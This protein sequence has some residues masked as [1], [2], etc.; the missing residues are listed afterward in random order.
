MNVF[1]KAQL[2][3]ASYVLFDYL[4]NDYSDGGVVDIL[5][6]AEQGGVFTPTQAE[7]FVN[8]WRV[9]SHTKNTSNGY[10]ATLFQSKATGEYVYAIRGTEPSDPINDISETD[11]GDIVIDGLALDQIVDMYNDWQRLITPEG[12]TFQAA[13]LTDLEAE[14]YALRLTP[15]GPARILHEQML[16][17]QGDIVIDG[18]GV[19]ATVRR[20][21]FDGSME[22]MPGSQAYG[23]GKLP[24]DQTVTAVG[25]SLG[26]HLAAGFTRL[27][28]DSNAAEA[29]TLNGAG[30]ATFG[31]GL[32][33][34]SN[35]TNLFGMLGGAS[36]FEASRIQNLYGS[37]GPEI[38]TM[39]FYLGLKQQGGHTGIFI[40]SWDDDTTW[41]HGKE[42]MTDALAIMDLFVRLDASLSTGDFALVSAR[43]NPIFEAA[44]NNNLA[45]FEAVLDAW[46]ALVLTG[47]SPLN[48][49]A[50]NRESLYSRIYAIRDALDGQQASVVSLVGLGAQTITDLA[51]APGGEA[52]RAALLA[53]SPFA[54]SGLDYTTRDGVSLYDPATGQ[55]ELTT[56]WLRDRAELLYWKLELALID[57]VT[58]AQIPL[59]DGDRGLLL[60]DRASGLLMHIHEVGDVPRI[61][62]GGADADLI[63]VPQTSLVGHRFYGGA[64]ADSLNGG[65]NSDYFEGGSGNDHLNGGKGNDTLIGGGDNDRYEF[66]TGDGSD[67]LIDSD[68]L[69][70]LWIDETHYRK[71]KKIAQGADTWVS[72]DNN[73]RFLRSGSDLLV[74]YG[75]GDSILIRNYVEGALGLTLEGYAPPEPVSATSVITGTADPDSLDGTTGD[76]RILGLDGND[77]IHYYVGDVAEGHD[78]LIGGAGSDV[79]FGGPGND[80]IYA[81]TEI[82]Q[83]PANPLPERGGITGDWLDGGSGADLIVGSGGMDGIFGGPGADTI[84]AGDGDDFIYSDDVSYA[85]DPYM[86]VAFGAGAVG[87][88][89]HRYVVTRSGTSTPLTDENADDVIMAGEGNDL[90]YSNR[91]NDY[92]EGNAGDDYLMG[93]TGNDSLIGGEDNDTL[94]GDGYDI[95]GEIYELKKAPGAEHGNDLLIGGQGN[96]LLYGNGGHDRLLGGEGQD[97]LF[98]DD[99]STPR[100]YHG[101][102]DLDGGAQD[103]LLYGLGGSDTL[104]GGGGNDKL[105]GDSDGSAAVPTTHGA[106]YLD[107]GEGDDSLQGDGGDDVLLGGDG[108]DRLDGDDNVGSDGISQVTGNDTLLGGAG[109]DQLLGGNGNDYL[110]GGAGADSLWGGLDND[111]LLGGDGDDHLEGRE[112]DDFL[113]GGLGDDVLLGGAGADTLQGGGGRDVLLGGAGD[114]LYLLKLSDMEVSEGLMGRIDDSDGHSRVHLLDISRANLSLRD[115]G[116][117]H[118]VLQVD[119]EHQMQVDRGLSGASLE[120]QFSDGRVSL[121]RLLGEAL[122]S[123]VARTDTT[124]TGAVYGG[125]ADDALTVTGAGGGATISGGRGND[126][127]TLLAVGGGTLLFS[128]GD[129]RDTLIGESAT[130]P[131][132]TGEN[133]LRLG[134]GIAFDDLRLTKTGTVSYVLSIGSEG[135]AILFNALGASKLP[136][137]FD[138][139]VFND[140]TEVSWQQVL[141]SGIHFDVNT[142]HITG[143]ETHDLITGSEV[144]R[145][146]EALEGND[147]IE[148]GVGSE[149]LLGGRGNDTYILNAGFGHDEISNKGALADEADRIIFG[150]GLSHADARFIR[151]GNDLLVWFGEIDRLRI[152]G[153]FSNEGIETLEFA[154]GQVFDRLHLPPYE[155]VQALATEETDTFGLGPGDDYF[156]ALGGDDFIAGEDGNDRLI[157][158]AGNDYLEG[159]AGDDWL[160]GGHGQDHLN[161]GAGVDTYE[162]SLTGLGY[163]R[164][165]IV[166]LDSGN[167]L[168][169][170]GGLRAQDVRVIR[171]Q[172]TST[173]QLWFLHGVNGEYSVVR[174][175][176]QLRGQGV[177]GPIAQVRFEAEPDVIWSAADLL[178][179]ALTGGPDDE[180]IFGLVDV[181][182]TLLGGGGNDRLVGGALDDHLDGEAGNDWL[183]GGAGNDRYTYGLGA[184]NDR[185]TDLEGL[186]RVELAQGLTPDDIELVRTAA[187]LNGVTLEHDS[188]VLVLR[189]SGESLVLEHFFKPGDA[190]TAVHFYDGT[191]WS[192]AELGLR[193]GNSVTGP[194]DTQTGGAG[195]DEFQ[196]DNPLDQVVELENGG[197]DNIISSVSYQLPANVENLQLTG[198]LSIDATGNNANNVLRGNAGDN[199]LDGRQGSDTYI[200]GAGNDTYIIR[201]NN[202]YPI[203][204]IFNLMAGLSFSLEERPGEGIDSI[205]TNAFVMHMPEEVEHLRVTSLID[206]RRIEFRGSGD[207]VCFRYTGNALNNRID[208]S[209]ADFGSF[210]SFLNTVRI[211]GGAGADTMLGSNIADTYVVD[212]AGD[213]IIEQGNSIDTVESRVSWQLGEKLENLLLT[214]DSATEGLGNELDNVLNGAENGAANR[215]SGFTGDDTYLIGLND[216]VIEAA[217]EGRDT[218]HLNERAGNTS[219][220]FHAQQWANIEV[221]KVGDKLGSVDLIGDDR[222][223]SLYGNYLSNLLE[224]GAGNDILYGASL[225]YNSLYKQFDYPTTALDRFSGGDG[226]DRI[227]AFGGHAEIEGGAGADLIELDGVISAEVEGGT[228]NDLIRLTGR[229]SSVAL[230]FGIGSGQDTVVSDH[231]RTAAA[232]EQDKNILSSVVVAADTQASRLRFTRE[233]ADM[234]VSLQ[235]STDSLRI[236]AFY[237]SRSSALIQSPIDSIRLA[238]GTLLNR[239]AIA[240]GLGRVEFSDATTAD[241]LLIADEASAVLSAGD[242]NDYLFGQAGEDHL[243]GEAGNDQLSGGGGADLLSGGAGDDLLMGGT[244][245]DLYTLSAGWGQDV[246]DDSQFRAGPT[247]FND[248]GAVDRILFDASVTADALQLE[249]DGDDLVLRH[250]SDSLRVVNY[251]SAGEHNGQVEEICFADGTLW[252]REQVVRM[253]NSIMGTAGNDVLTGL[254]SESLVFGLGGDDTL[255]GFGTLDGGEGNDRIDG[256]GVLHGGDGQDHLTGQGA[257]RLEGGAGDDLLI[258]YDHVWEPRSSTLEGGQGNDTLYGSFGEDSYLF[259][260]GDGRDLLIERR[261]DQA[262]SNV[263]ASIDYLHFGDGIVA[264]DLVFSRQGQDLLIEHANG[265]DAIT[266]QNWFRG[267]TAHFKLDVFSFAD[268]SELSQAEIEARV[269]YKGTSAADNLVGTDENDTFLG[270]AGNDQIWGRAGDDLIHGEAGNDYLEGELG[271]DE[272]YGGLGNDQLRGGAG[273]DL[274]AGGAGDDTY[275]Y[276]LGDGA[277]E[278]QVGG[279]QDGLFFNGGITVE[280]LSFSREQDDLLIRVDQDDAQS[281]R[282]VG[283][284]LGGHNALSFVQPEGGSMLTA[285]RIAQIISGEVPPG[286]GGNTV[287]GTA[288]NDQLS[289][290]AGTDVLRGLAGNDTLFGMGGD[291]QIEGGDGDDYLS[292]GN[293]QLG[294]SGNDLLNGGAGND[295]LAGEDGNDT[296]IGGAGDDDYYYRVNGGVDVIDNSGGGFDG[297]FFLDVPRSRLSF[298]RDGDDLVV[299]VDGDL[300]QQVRVTNHF[301]GGDHSIDYVQPDG[302]NYLTT[303]QIAAQLTAVPGGGEEPGEPEEPGNPGGP[304]EPPVAGVGGDDLLV[305]TAGNDIL[306]GGAGNDTLSGA[307]GND[308]LLGGVGEDTYTYTAGQ[309]VIEEVGGADTLVFAG[310]ITFNQVASGL[311]KSGNDLV[312]RVNGST[313]N[314]V[315]LKNFFLGGDNLVETIAFETGGQLTAAQIFGAFGLPV[316]TPAAAFDDIIQGSIGDDALDGTAGNDLLQGGNGDD[317][318]FGDAGADRLEGGNGNDVLAG[319]AGNDTLV[320]G[321]S[322]DTYVF[323]VGGGQDVID[324]SGGGADTLRFEGISFNQVASGLMKSGN[325][326]VLNV[327]GGSDKV[328]IR[329]W[330]LGGDYVVDTIAFASGGQVTA[331]QLFGAFGLSNP[332]PLGSLIYRHLPDER[333]FGTV[334][335]GQAG[336]QIIRGSSDDDLIDGGAGND[337][338]CGNTGHDYL[339]GGAGNDT[340]V[341]AA[342]DG[343]DVI[344]NLSNTPDADSDVLS[345][346]DIGRENL[347]LSRQGDDLVIDVTGTEDSITI[348]DWYADPAQQLDVIQ[349]GSSSLSANQVDN[350][351]NAMAAFGAP[352][353]GEI[354]LTSVQRDQLNT[355]I[356]ANWQ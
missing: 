338:L 220:V 324:N 237:E 263:E 257:D 163:S 16:L 227:Y 249:I 207:D 313:A 116:G 293:G 105:Y 328:T 177:F 113:N 322:D 46:G 344:N 121:D 169:M 228:G 112:G 96:D 111:T 167:Q 130:G 182:N 250:Q 321:R 73:V 297:V 317:E 66:A 302:G 162:I 83:G 3:E 341:F 231:I 150:E 108:N 24:F 155:G 41:G 11:I 223:N 53:L 334:L 356:A 217:G 239:D 15:P 95:A 275:V 310:G 128:A 235:G 52:Y 306:L 118:L 209:S 86:Q 256:T 28:G 64:G 57:G 18:T 241:D 309:D 61:I 187:P 142:G 289:G 114:D 262:Y 180:G 135:D 255:E 109:D 229:P 265:E 183:L 168:I 91:G 206:V 71:G 17:A 47:Y 50:E 286:G 45:S 154:D 122:L 193:A 92:V 27:F 65:G 337:T 312:L 78:T 144:A 278:I 152:T 339:I 90:V 251:F 232:W 179:M 159:N 134:E 277:D 140:G 12:Q 161:G 172:Q 54:L 307:A 195:D 258:A 29:L 243:Y 347:W 84:S 342:G 219:T 204:P 97:T 330:F 196:V 39:D 299:L 348:Q 89:I 236:T 290:T 87:P 158:G 267:P 20:I 147:R 287:T 202:Q 175:Q 129:G 69:G 214:G 35:T 125:A 85:L 224:G 314:Q 165:R 38:V 79:I 305:G 126:S 164:T 43:L 176:D 62:F 67:I 30:Y 283:H 212:D 99:R 63:S 8:V 304:G 331:D 36:D 244:G 355:V 291:D 211:D 336:N 300:G 120:F 327:S 315:T 189:D 298:H 190:Q 88:D 106:D 216:T 230:G 268:G 44:S 145:T 269:V 123:R 48:G 119:D 55:G 303:A 301:L 329:N 181:A 34:V 222:D 133:T 332:D 10:S 74:L 272:I 32:N 102:D 203:L 233:G 270:G 294:G 60:E 308:T 199:R 82:S 194:A 292:G 225:R 221:I 345:I 51:T 248:D 77:R 197:T 273:T 13:R 173:L 261:P 136:R 132:R 124:G 325:D 40:E 68:G 264:S 354:N 22:V 320:G 280:R 311:M 246:I 153:F 137:P 200:G 282:V 33:A 234:L 100:E 323:A 21:E 319:G 201:D 149:I 80:A 191:V 59:A 76:D 242:G 205:E 56:E 141:D 349:A 26:G 94:V 333:S 285:A 316:P 58:D 72:E 143:T 23:L 4:Q 171:D 101:N 146:I 110:D 215:L 226:D 139:V 31:V 266:V 184:G 260:L 218:L 117:G 2:A 247:F 166:D 213:V 352:A 170:G 340:Y 296:L 276:G 350:L 253:A 9:I 208:L 81:F 174:L 14:T 240:T 157:G 104:Q 19:F 252:R 284:F 259:N 6:T 254:G 192:H 115:G 138:R 93:D 343:Q 210:G 188:L 25:H 156:N 279:G 131:R 151:H 318:L 37:A 274:L 346:A 281:V 326:L 49:K 271:N 288:S 127:L 178:R 5:Q 353:G 148:S 335:A 295:I 75:Q 107:G 160:V 1:D 185:V 7:N 245:A 98:G 42:Q 103:D 198:I 351:V 186:N 238:S 70:S